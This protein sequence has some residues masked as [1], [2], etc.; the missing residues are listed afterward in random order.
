MRSPS[1]PHYSGGG[2]G[3]ARSM[4][5][6]AR[7]GADAGSGGW[8]ERAAAFHRAACTLLEQ[9]SA[10]S[11]P[12]RL[13]AIHAVEL[14][15]SAFLASHGMAATDIRKMGHD[16]AAR[17]A[18]VRARG[19]VLRHGTAAHLAAMTEAQEYVALRYRPMAT[20]TLAPANRMAATL[21]EVSEKVTK[22]IARR[23]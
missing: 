12:A 7:G 4:K 15:L 10:V 20:G 21:G 22:A 23:G 19:L 14:Y 18:A 3:D 13:C 2:T 8:L 11:A 16:L 9:G 6:E 1:G 17:G 5:D